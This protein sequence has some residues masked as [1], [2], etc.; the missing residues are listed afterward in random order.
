[1]VKVIN[2]FGIFMKGDVLKT[3]ENGCRNRIIKFVNRS[4]NSSGAKKETRY[5][6]Q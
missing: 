2:D 4:C 5:V 1:M 6:M 3:L